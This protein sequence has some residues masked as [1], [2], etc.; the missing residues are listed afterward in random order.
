VLAALGVAGRGRVGE[1][2]VA[3]GVRVHRSAPVR[4]AAELMVEEL[5]DALPVVDDVGRVVGI[6]T[7][8]DIVRLV[9]GRE[10]PS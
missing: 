7:W 9:A 4:H 5:V 8:S 2:V 10:L 1:R 6:V 3:R